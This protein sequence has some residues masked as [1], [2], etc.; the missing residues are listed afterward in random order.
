MALMGSLVDNFCAATLDTAT[1]NAV[2][3]AGN[4]GFQAGCRYTFIVSAG[5]TGDATLTSNVAYDLTGSHVHV[6]LIDAG[7]QEAGLETYPIILTEVAANQDD[8]LLIVV[9]NGTVG[10]YE[11]VGGVPNGLAFPS[12][13]PVA[14]RWWRIRES[15]GTVYYESA[16]DVRGP[17]TVQASVVP[18]VNIA[19]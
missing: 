17:W 6:A 18:T 15:G 4:S 10:I 2:N 19:A 1:W 5:M 16:P 8:S 14:M 7:V 3:S 12:Y 11:V 13:D 9:S